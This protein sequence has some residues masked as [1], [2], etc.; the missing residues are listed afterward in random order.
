MDVGWKPPQTLWVLAVRLVIQ[1]SA[2]DRAWQIYLMVKR[3]LGCM[4]LPRKQPEHGPLAQDLFCGI[5]GTLG[6]ETPGGWE[7]ELSMEFP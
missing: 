5:V 1:V 4:S 7:K 2:M 3:N 6:A